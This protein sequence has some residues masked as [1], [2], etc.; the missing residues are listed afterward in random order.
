[1][2]ATLIIAPLATTAFDRGQH[3]LLGRPGD[4]SPLSTI[5]LTAAAIGNPVEALDRKDHL[6]KILQEQLVAVQFRL[7]RLE[8]VHRVPFVT[9][10]QA[11]ELAMTVEDGPDASTLTD[12]RLP[13]ASGHRHGKQPAMDHCLFDLGR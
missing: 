8:H 4:V 1:M 7:D 2:P 13:A 9:A 5:E 6:R 12:R 3:N 10:D 11:H